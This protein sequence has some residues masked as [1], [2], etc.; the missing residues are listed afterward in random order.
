MTKS[1]IALYL[2]LIFLAGA[3]AGGAL[4]LST[5]RTFGLDHYQRRHGSPEDFANFIWNK[6]KDRLELDADQ[7][8]KV[9]P[10]FRAGFA[11]VRAIQDRSLQE[12]E[13]AIRKNHEE[14]S[15]LLTEKQRAEL[16]KMNEERQE[17][18]R[19]RGGKPAS[20]R[21]APEKPAS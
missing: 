17:F 16:E 21:S 4:V 18:F 3:I 14:I 1:K 13:A 19:K 20:P 5:P 2:V 10:I 6:M 9:E 15:T 8:Q 12:V 11:E 7:I